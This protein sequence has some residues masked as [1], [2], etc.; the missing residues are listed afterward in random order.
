MFKLVHGDVI[1]ITSDA[2]VLAEVVDGFRR[3][4]PPPE[5]GQREQS[6]IVPAIHMAIGDKRVQLPL[7]HDAVRHVQARV[8]PYQRLVQAQDLQQPVVRCSPGLELEGAQGVRDLLQRV[9]DTV[10][11]VVGWVD[12]PL[13]TRVRVSAELDAVRDEV[14]HVKVVVP[15]VHLH[16]ERGLS[17]IHE[18]QA[19][20]LEEL[21]RLRDGPVAPRAI[22]LQ[23]AVLRNL[24]ARLVVHVGVA[25]FYE[26]H[27]EGVQLIEVVARVSYP[28]WLPAHPRND[29]FDVVD[30]LRLLRG[31]IGVVETKAT[32]AVVPLGHA[33]VHEHGLGVADVEVPIRLGREAG[34]DLAAGFR[35]VLLQLL[36]GVRNP[37]DVA[38]AKV[39]SRVHNVVLAGLRQ[40]CVRVRRWLVGRAGLQLLRLGRGGSLLLRLLL[41]LLLRALGHISLGLW[42]QNFEDLRIEFRLEQL[43]VGPP[44]VS[45]CFQLREQG[46]HASVPLRDKPLSLAVD[47]LLQRRVDVLLEHGNADATGTPE[48]LRVQRF[49]PDALEVLEAA[50]KLADALEL[51]V[52]DAAQE[53]G[54]MH[55][56]IRRELGRGGVEQVPVFPIA[57]FPHARLVDDA[58]QVSRK[59]IIPHRIQGCFL[60]Q[61]D[62]LEPRDEVLPPLHVLLRRLPHRP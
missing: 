62:C 21:E 41:L 5:P 52:H 16:P 39:D 38:V 20:V 28:I 44:H 58:R 29:L 33:E 42:P 35:Q 14:V 56:S 18:T 55:Q 24:V 34:H 57:P 1:G 8:L 60:V 10:G 4:T 48:G 22:L 45:D 31:G 13:V 53:H 26:L 40:K 36:L 7:A 37:H 61:V 49:L 3:G 2:D 19:H 11:E 59:L 51:V 32:Q 17:L 6:G 27:R 46:V 15:H 30:V 50:I 9:H 43:L 47:H 25:R 23:R 12:A 54:P